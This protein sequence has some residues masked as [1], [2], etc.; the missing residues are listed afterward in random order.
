MVLIPF[1]LL[2]GAIRILINNFFLDYEYNLPNFPADPYGFTTEDRLYWGKISLNYLVNDKGIEYLGDL[3]FPDGKPFYNERELS[4][5]LDVKNLIQVTLKIWY[6]GLIVLAALWVWSWRKKW[7]PD[8][9]R[10]ISRGGFL[11]IGLIIA[12]LLGVFL[13]FDAL[14]RGFHA[15]FFTGDTWLFYTSDSLIRLFPEKLW[16]DAFFYMGIFSLTGAIVLGIL[17][18]RNSQK[19]D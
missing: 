10:G 7:Q 19:K 3:K 14:F 5:M 9:W 4:H 15:I 6:V 17:G 1:L 12:V 13:N 8:F 18:L 16:S 11:T 2:M